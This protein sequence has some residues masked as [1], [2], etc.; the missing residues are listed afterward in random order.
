MS[1]TKSRAPHGA[2]GLKHFGYAK[3]IKKRGRAPHGARGL[4]P[5]AYQIPSQQ[6]SSRPARGAWIE[7]T[8]GG[9]AK[10]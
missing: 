4:K 3:V 9:S 1:E 8:A 7:T 10:S 2:R 6:L 5:A